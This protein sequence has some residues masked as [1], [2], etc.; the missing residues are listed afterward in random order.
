MRKMFNPWLRNNRTWQNLVIGYK[1]CQILNYTKYLPSLKCSYGYGLTKILMYFTQILIIILSRIGKN[2]W[3]KWIYWIFH[4][5][6]T[7]ECLMCF[8]IDW[9]STKSYKPIPDKV[10][11]AYQLYIS[12]NF[13]LQAHGWFALVDSFGWK[14]F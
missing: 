7:E 3:Q 9:K 5:A 14:R 4:K 6:Q 8:K 11:F 2:M 13:N 1:I 12:L 10:K